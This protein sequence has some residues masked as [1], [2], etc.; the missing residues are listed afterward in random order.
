MPS[1]DTE[2]GTSP[3]WLTLFLCIFFSKILTCLSK[4]YES[5]WKNTSQ[6]STFTIWALG[7]PLGT[8]KGYI[9]GLEGWFVICGDRV[10]G[11]HRNNR[12]GLKYIKA[13]QN[14]DNAEIPLRFT[15]SKR[16]VTVRESH[17]IS[18]VILWDFPQ[19]LAHV[20]KNLALQFRILTIP[21]KLVTKKGLI[22]LASFCTGLLSP[23]NWPY[24]S[25]TVKKTSVWLLML[26]HQ[27]LPFYTQI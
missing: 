15:T 23:H 22:V 12:I 2:R 25:Y 24:S 13:T 11:W 1:L 27:L 20:N 9:Q 14:A 17:R 5:E 10:N 6:K 26:I 18:D 8:W 7:T 3:F 21:F 16:W 4:H 19:H